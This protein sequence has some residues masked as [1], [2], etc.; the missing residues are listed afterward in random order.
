MSP[1]VRAVASD[2][3][4]PPRADV[5]VI[6]GGISGVA[7]AWELA[8]RG[9]SVA[10]V[11]K[12]VIGGEQS[13]RNWGWCRQQNRDERELPLAILAMRMWDTL[14]EEA[15]ADVGFRRSGL[16][17]T[18]SN[19]A[20][21]AAWEAWGRMARGYGVDS[22]MISGV[23]AAAL[24]PHHAQPWTGGVHSPTDGRAEP[25][26][27]VPVM[28]EAARRAGARLHQGCAAREIEFAGGRVSGV[29][30]ETGRIG[31]DAV[32]V[33][34]GAWAGMLLRHQGV[35][36]LQASIQS[37]SFATE[38]G[39]ELLAGGHSM[40][41]L[42][43]R[44][45]L[46][47]GYTV[48]LSGFGKLHIAPMGMLQARPFWP[49]FLQRRAKLS[50]TLN[51][52]FLTG[53]DSLQRWRADGRSPFERV[54]VLDPAPDAALLRR[55]LEGL[56]RAY[57]GLAGLRIAHAWGGMVDCTPDAIP[58]IGPVRSRPGLFISAGHTGHGFGTGPAAGRLAA[59]LIRGDAPSVDPRPFRYERMIDGTDLG[60]MGMM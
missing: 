29:V 40:P 51:R 54:R 41:D 14:A 1:P 36:F 8:R 25:A 13:S 38:P 5:V 48:G 47:G 26:L 56:A 53:P 2:A 22:R 35:P 59:E 42:T 55:G 32:L 60:S 44:R 19:Q 46:D 27:A 37:T 23:E 30:T 43:L 20:D 17:Y 45:R 39:A 28:A 52:N 4:L 6:G 12:G 7:A 24:L 57:P 50:L 31:C 18:S 16:V 9:S 11:E 15:G 49:T 10:L 34:G 21:L 3:S 33:A 58:V